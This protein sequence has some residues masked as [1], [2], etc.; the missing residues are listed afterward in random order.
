M[1][2]E[3]ILTKHPQGKAGVNIL[4]SKYEV[5][6]KFI[7]KTLEEKKELS[8]SKLCDLAEEELSESFE[9]K[10]IWYVVSVKLDL[11]ARELIERVPKTSPHRLRLKQIK[12]L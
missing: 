9:G 10:I 6:K 12:Q 8:F 5:I 3:R 2:E 11:E 7:L 1:E 4:K